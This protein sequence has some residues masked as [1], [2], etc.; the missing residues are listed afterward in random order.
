MDN[1]DD[2]CRVL[3]FEW[4][5]RNCALSLF[6][7]SEIV[8]IYIFSST[9]YEVA[10]IREVSMFKL[11]I[12]IGLLLIAS[13]PGFA[14]GQVHKG[15]VYVCMHLGPQ[16]IWAKDLRDAIAIARP[17]KDLGSQAGVSLGLFPCFEEDGSSYEAA[18]RF[19]ADKNYPGS[20]PG[21][22]WRSWLIVTVLCKSRSK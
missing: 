10:L 5:A 13:T 3:N 1:P 16:C 15:A 21:E 6:N 20:T 9:L 7:K 17:Y 11:L 22:I 8:E 4:G 19:V 12:A 2:H 14:G 18:S